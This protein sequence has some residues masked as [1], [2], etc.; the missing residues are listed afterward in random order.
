MNLTDTQKEEI[1]SIDED[2][3][4]KHR[5]LL[6]ASDVLNYNEFDQ[7]EFYKKMKELEKEKNE[8]RKKILTT[9]QLET[10]EG[11]VLEK[12]EEKKGRN[13]SAQINRMNLDYP[14]V[15]L[16]DDQNI[17][18]FEKMEAMKEEGWANHG[19]RKMTYQDKQNEIY[20]EV[21]DERQ[22]TL[23]EKINREKKIVR[24]EEI[25]SEY[26][27]ALPVTEE[28]IP[29]LEEFTLPKFKTLRKKLDAKISA[30]DKLAIEQ[31]R[32]ERQIS[33]DKR[34]QQIL[35]DEFDFLEFEN[36]ELVRYVDYTKD[37]VEENANN[38][39]NLWSTDMEN[40]FSNEKSEA[41]KMTEKYMNEINSLEAEL[42]W[43]T[44]E[45]I[46]KGVVIVSKEYPVPPV[47]I[48]LSEVNDFPDEL[49]M[50]FLLLDPEVDFSI[51]LPDFEK[52]EGEHFASV[53]PNPAVKNQ[54]LNFFLKQDTHVTVEILDESGRTL[55][56]LASESMNKGQQKLEVNTNDLNAQLYFYRITTDNEVT[57]L[58]F[59][60]VK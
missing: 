15:D 49:K 35:D 13:L 53:Y 8:A 31:L 24:E 12:Q 23:Y 36:P 59:T 1:K 60:V 21:L 45:T 44:R 43:T 7:A 57:M 11:Y 10:Y 42:L 25:L 28:L 3:K 20:K 40:F 5:E 26:K 47:S 55:K 17:A 34:L 37:L 51:D 4:E 38:I 29:M 6:E 50:L 18:L 48:I 14:G 27:K 56:T 30:Q 58:K 16:T 54:T 9:E 33:F 39:A 19:K 41:M 32:E 2:Y 52:G 22:F 46:K